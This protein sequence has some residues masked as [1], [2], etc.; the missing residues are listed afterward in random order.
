[1]LLQY[2]I[3][4]QVYYRANYMWK[5]VKDVELQLLSFVTYYFIGLSHT[6]KN[7]I[8]SCILRA[9]TFISENMLYLTGGGGK[10]KVAHTIFPLRRRMS[11]NRTTENRLSN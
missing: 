10:K 8:L 3:M 5:L 9:T 4:A 2:R 11:K 1:M 7:F 6:A